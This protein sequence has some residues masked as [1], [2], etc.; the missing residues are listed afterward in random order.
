MGKR[1][2]PTLTYFKTICAVFGACSC[3]RL[4][5]G[6]QSLRVNYGLG[7]SGMG[8]VRFRASGPGCSG[9]LNDMHSGNE[10]MDPG[11][12]KLS[13]NIVPPS[14]PSQGLGLDLLA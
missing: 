13:L 4:G 2:P 11:S 1:E 12:L 14:L 8:V 9:A 7:L 10:D 5:F 3:R 6:V